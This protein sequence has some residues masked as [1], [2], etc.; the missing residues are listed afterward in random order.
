MSRMWPTRT[1]M[2]PQQKTIRTSVNDGNDSRR[3]GIAVLVHLH[4]AANCSVQPSTGLDV[5][6]AGNDGVEG[7]V[8]ARVLVLDHPVVRRHVHPRA[9]FV[10]KVSSHDG[11]GGAHVLLPKEEL[12]VEVCHVDGVQID[13]VDVRNPRHGKVLQYLAPQPPGPHDENPGSGE[14]A[15]GKVRRRHPGRRSRNGFEFANRKSPLLV[16][17]GGWTAEQGEE[18]A[19]AGR[20]PFVHVHGI[21][22]GRRRRPRSLVGF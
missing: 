17:E 5:V 2:R 21:V 22:T 3:V 16:A 9:S 4:Q 11:L 18:G 12:P 13:H 7:R 1:K 14:R 15:F 20:A 19:S 8:E 10:D 6:E